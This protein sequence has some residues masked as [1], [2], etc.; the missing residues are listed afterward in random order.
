MRVRITV[1]DG[2][3]K[4][5]A[6]PVGAKLVAIP[7]TTGPMFKLVD[8]AGDDID[9]VGLVPL[10]L[11]SPK[12][13]TA[14]GSISLVWQSGGANLAYVGLC[15]LDEGPSLRN[16]VLQQWSPMESNG[17]AGLV[18]TNAGDSLTFFSSEV[19]PQ[20]MIIEVHP[21]GYVGF[22][23]PTAAEANGPGSLQATAESTLARKIAARVVEK[24]TVASG[25]YVA[26]PGD[27]V[28]Y[29]TSAGTFTIQMPPAETSEAGDVVR[30]I[31]QTTT[32]LVSQDIALSLNGNDALIQDWTTGEMEPDVD[33]GGLAVP[34]YYTAIT[35]EFDGVG[36]RL[37]AL[38]GF[39]L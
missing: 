13:G 8:A 37:I 7:G 17:V 9:E 5:T 14:V 6:L 31:D 29:D 10:S 25:A 34:R 2:F 20:T 28:P 30:F 16:L 15:Y 18:A 3:T 33:I 26:S 39:S 1:T 36:W 35:F 11:L 12:L 21:V 38:T 27:C 22:A 23:A 19:G 32:P 24:Q 4:T